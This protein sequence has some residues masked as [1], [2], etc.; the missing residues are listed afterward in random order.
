MRTTIAKSLMPALLG[1]ALVA[2]APANADE[3]HH[4]SNVPAPQQPGATPSM[5]MMNMTGPS[6]SGTMTAMPIMN[7]IGQG[8]MGMMGSGAM[9]M[10]GMPDIGAHLEGRIAFLRAE[11]G[12]T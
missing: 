8:G 2:V 3:Q 11:L 7:M 12:V 1:L 4:E 6:A 5:P 9:P 10:E